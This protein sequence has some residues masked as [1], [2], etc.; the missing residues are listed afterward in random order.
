MGRPENPEFTLNERRDYGCEFS[1][2]C[3]TCHLPVC[4]EEMPPADV[5]TLAITMGIDLDRRT[6]GR[7]IRR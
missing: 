6:L 1:R 5:K 4:R 7:K 3:L 2:H